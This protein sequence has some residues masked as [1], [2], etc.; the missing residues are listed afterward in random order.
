VSP[1]KGEPFSAEAIVI[2]DLGRVETVVQVQASGRD[3]LL[4]SEPSHLDERL[5]QRHHSGCRGLPIGLRSAWTEH[6]SRPLERDA[7]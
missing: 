3:L 5:G 4:L 2:S 7:H 6:A 1:K